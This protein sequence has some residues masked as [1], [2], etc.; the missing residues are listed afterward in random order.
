MT[1][2]LVEQNAAMALAVADR[3]VV[4]EVGQVALE[5][6][7]DELAESEAVRERYLGVAP[8]ADRARRRSRRERRASR[9]WST[10]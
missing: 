8:S 4:L 2:V 1:V 7:A 5:G 10:A 9:S 3:A 6:R